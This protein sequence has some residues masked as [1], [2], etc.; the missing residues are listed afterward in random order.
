[1]E[2][3]EYLLKGTYLQVCVFGACAHIR[4]QAIIKQRKISIVSYHEKKH[5]KGENN[6]FYSGE[7]GK[8][9]DLL[10]ISRGFDKMA[11]PPVLV[12]S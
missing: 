4:V 5:T 12:S 6:P 10:P 11:S 7:H 8:I 1:M 3:R 9:H 2:L